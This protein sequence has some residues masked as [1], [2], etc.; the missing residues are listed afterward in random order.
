MVLLPAWRSQSA[1]GAGQTLF[2]HGPAYDTV[3]KKPAIMR[4]F[5][6]QPNSY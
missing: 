4:D 1:G 5:L 3:L 2:F 6:H